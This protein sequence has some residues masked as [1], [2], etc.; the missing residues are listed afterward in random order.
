MDSDFSEIEE[1]ITGWS[2]SSYAVDCEQYL[3]THPEVIEHYAQEL[4]TRASYYFDW[5][6]TQIYWGKSVADLNQMNPPD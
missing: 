2:C 1:Q 4:T 6:T 3:N 5:A